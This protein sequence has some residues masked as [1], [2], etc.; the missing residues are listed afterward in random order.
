MH[1]NNGTTGMTDDHV[2][3]ITIGG[4]E[5]S[6]HCHKVLDIVG[7]SALSPLTTAFVISPAIFVIQ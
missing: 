1:T 5:V 4:S 3:F 7:K 2:D 6:D